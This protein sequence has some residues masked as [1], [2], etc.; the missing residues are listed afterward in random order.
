MAHNRKY[1]PG[2]VD[3]IGWKLKYCGACDDQNK[4]EKLLIDSNFFEG[5][6]FTWVSLIWHYTR[7]FDLVPEYRRMSKTHRELPI[8]AELDGKILEWA[9]KHNRKLLYDIFMIASMEVLIHVGK[10]Y[11]RNIDLLVA[12]RAKYGALPLTIEECEKWPSWSEEERIERAIDMLKDDFSVEII[13]KVMT[14]SQEK[15]HELKASLTSDR[16]DPR[17]PRHD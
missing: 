5:Q 16:D 2:G 15:V 10:K 7:K 14:L 9:D 11:K 6:P 12:E 3:V 4:V 1:V 17:N 13:A 8:A